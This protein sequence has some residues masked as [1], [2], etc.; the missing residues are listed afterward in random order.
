MSAL[1]CRSAVVPMSR[2]HCDARPVT[3]TDE[4]WG[5]ALTGCSFDP[6]AWTIHFDVDVNEFGLTTRYDLVL[7][8]VSDWRATRDVPLPWT[9]AE[10]TEVHVSELDD[11]VVVRLVLWTDGTTVTLR[12]ASVRVESK[13]HPGQR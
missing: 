2:K 4:L 1:F 7:E 5:S 11:E 8:G 13:Q 3:S 9:Y 6:V 10:L 12:C